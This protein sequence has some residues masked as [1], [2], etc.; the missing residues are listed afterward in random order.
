M[1]K[2]IR[3]VLSACFLLMIALQPAA[4][5][6]A[7]LQALTAWAM[8]VVPSLLPFLMAAPALCCP[9]TA[10]LLS[11]ATGGFLRLLRLPKNC[12]GAL[13]TGLLSGSPGGAVALACCSR[14][15]ADEPGSFLRASLVFSGASPA[16][17]TGVVA[18]SFLN[19]PG[20]GWLL[21][22]S[23][24]ISGLLTALFTR[25]PSAE[26]VSSA[27]P[28]AS[29]PSNAALRAA[30]TLMTIAGYM[31]FFSV[32]GAL[33]ALLFSPSLKTP[34]LALLELAGGCRALCALP[35]SLSLRLPL[36]SAAASFG[37]VSVT[38]QCLS[39]L[40]PLG[41]SA[42]EY[43]AGKLLHAALCALL[44]H[45]QLRLSASSADLP[46]ASW[47]LLAMLLLLLMFLT[48]RRWLTARIRDI[49]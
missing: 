49:S 12:S 32:L 18:V 42:S 13:I 6:E 24:V 35:A 38:M 44:T 10:A 19:A 31:T 34:L 43:I 4:A 14:D 25:F 16:F 45:L 46:L 5:T 33:L 30:L 23:Q 36:I 1:Q 40:S 7:A 37:G 29:L 15:E 47:L 8:N 39:V 3:P 41:V 17:L 28:A 48:L 9:E 11:R 26:R 21:V 2:W 22:R 20:T 27:M